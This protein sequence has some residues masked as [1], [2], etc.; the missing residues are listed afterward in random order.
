MMM[1]LFITGANGFVGRRVVRALAAAQIPDIR[2]LLREP[3]DMAATY[4]DA[5][6]W[7]FIRGRLETPTQWNDSLRGA[8]AILHLAS[9]TGK[10]SPRVHRDIIVRGTEQLLASARVAG[11]PR[12]LF[13]SSVAAG[14]PNRRYY[15]YAEAKRRAEAAVD[16]SALDTLIVRPTMVLGPGSA[17]GAALRRLALLPAPVVF[18]SGTTL[19]Q[20]IHVD[21]LADLLIAS[22]ASPRAWDGQTL[23][24]GGRDVVNIEE[25]LRRFRMTVT[26]DHP[27]WLHVPIEPL[28]T[29][30]GLL[31]PLLRAVMPLTAGQLATFANDGVAD[32][33][34]AQWTTLLSDRALPLRGL[35][36]MLTPAVTHVS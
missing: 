29:V 33:R 31:E 15:A 11:V 20:P 9:S 35:D 28:R 34:G 36:A 16:A 21:D 23:T 26:A 19:V 10:A 13:V 25:L 32:E 1:P 6:G 5:P 17:L 2:L 30:L 27:R 22:L 24:V 4:R 12:F 8:G 14:F 18:G 3:D 7:Q